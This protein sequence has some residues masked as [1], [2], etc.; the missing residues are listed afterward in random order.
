MT[1]LNPPTSDSRAML[2]SGTVE[3]DMARLCLGLGNAFLSERHVVV[4]VDGRRLVVSRLS[5][6]SIEVSS[7]VSV[8]FVRDPSPAVP[9]GVVGNTNC[10]WGYRWCGGRTVGLHSINNLVSASDATVF[11]ALVTNI[12]QVYATVVSHVPHSELPAFTTARSS[13]RSYVQLGVIA[14]G[15]GRRLGGKLA[16]LGL[17]FGQWQQRLGL[18]GYRRIYLCRRAS[19]WC[20]PCGSG[21]ICALSICD[22]PRRCAPQLLIPGRPSLTNSRASASG[23][24]V[25]DVPVPRATGRGTHWRSC[26]EGVGLHL[27]GG[28]ARSGLSEARS[29]AAGRA[30]AQCDCCCVGRH[31]S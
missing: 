27:Q 30:G 12:P 5:G 17:S 21:I 11:S 19:G 13:V 6:N 2:V 16:I 23:V 4:G 28:D 24:A 8:S 3:S 9:G 10:G 22:R 25:G 20:C 18:S 26:L 7:S 29:S 1:I 15:F 31:A 14:A